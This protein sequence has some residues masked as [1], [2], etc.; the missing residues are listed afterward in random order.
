[1]HPGPLGG[2][3]DGVVQQDPRH[4]L[5][6]VPAAGDGDALVDVIAQ[7]PP[8]L[9]GH[10]L[11][12]Q[13]RVHHG[14]GQIHRD[15]GG[16]QPP[17]VGPGQGQH[18]LHQP[19][20]PPAGPADVV[21]IRLLVRLNRRLL[22]QVRRGQNH[23]QG[24]FQLMGRVGQEPALLVQ[25]PGHRPG[26][27]AR[28][29]I[30][31]PQQ[32]RQGRYAYNQAHFHHRPEGGVL[33]GGVGEG[34]AGIQRP[35]GPE[36][37]QMIAAQD[38]GG[39]PLLQAGS[40]DLRHGV[41]VVQPVIAAAGQAHGAAG[42][43]VRHKAGGGGPLPGQGGVIPPGL[44]HLHEPLVHGALHGGPAGHQHP[45]EHRQQH[46]RHHGH[47]DGHDLPAKAADHASTSRK[48]PTIRRVRMVTAECR[49]VSFRRRKLIY[50]STLL[51]SASES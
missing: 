45:H 26:G 19:L 46:R 1:M 5:Q 31:A 6:L 43:H 38:A 34:D 36:I 49:W 28:Q 24:R 9:E 7:L 47:V 20:H 22:H 18:I 25:G 11:E 32:H 41:L 21:H 50:T 40:D 51:S 42:G 13:R 23:R 15:H 27:Q 10:R 16:L 4:L 48:Y 33:L 37:P 35:V 14:V 44:D 30:A 3:F 8:G 2:V 17:V 12:P 39:I 29:Q